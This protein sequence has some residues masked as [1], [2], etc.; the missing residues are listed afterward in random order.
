M[1][2]FQTC[3]LGLVYQAS[4][5]TSKEVS[6]HRITPTSDGKWHKIVLYIHKHKHPKK[7]AVDLYIDCKLV[8]NKKALVLLEDII[9]SSRSSSVASVFNFAQ[10]EGDKDSRDKLTWKVKE[11][12]VLGA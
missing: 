11:T 5:R 8:G 10:K 4:D 1:S 7:T 6:F 3:K 2:C 12:H 9:P